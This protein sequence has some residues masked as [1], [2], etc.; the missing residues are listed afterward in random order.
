MVLEYDR[1]F[2]TYGNDFIFYD[3]NNPLEIPE[4][5]KESF[6]LVVADPPFLAEECLQKTAQTIK[7][8]AKDKILICTGK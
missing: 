4:E 3:Y 7:F 6:D 5:L 8:M 1:R 2:E